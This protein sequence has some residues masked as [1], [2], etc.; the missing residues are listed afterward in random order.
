MEF[1]AFFDSHEIKLGKGEILEILYC[2]AY[3]GQYAVAFEE[4]KRK[5]M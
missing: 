5:Q 2:S 3:S 4:L 1:S